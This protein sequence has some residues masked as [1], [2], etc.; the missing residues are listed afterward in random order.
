MSGPYPHPWRQARCDEERGRAGS[1]TR[2]TVLTAVKVEWVE[3]VVIQESV[4]ASAGAAVA[5]GVADRVVLVHTSATNATVAATVG[6]ARQ[7]HETEKG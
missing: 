7:V 3:V 6:P 2:R 5:A 1:A 4:L